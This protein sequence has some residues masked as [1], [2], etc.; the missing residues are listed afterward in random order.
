MVQWPAMKWVWATSMLLL[1]V[2]CLGVGN[3]LGQK[4]EEGRD[5]L[6][7]A[8]A[9]V[10]M[11]LLVLR[12]VFRFHPEWDYALLPSDAYAAVRPWW[13]FPFACVSL[14]IGTRRMSTRFSRRGVAVCAGLLLV[15]VASRLAA[16]AAIDPA[17]L[18]GRPGADGVCRQTTDYS[19][20]AA[21]AATLLSRIGL[22]AGEGEMAEACGTTALTGTDE[23][24]VCRGLRR[25]LAGTG[26]L[27]R[28]VSSDW[29][30]LHGRPLPAMA[31]VAFSFLVDHW[32]VVLEADAG[33]VVVGDPLKSRVVR[34]S[35]ETFLRDWRGVLVV[36][37]NE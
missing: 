35:K 19:C 20:G 36:V 37:Q 28:V 14:G 7:L 3:W 6:A 16:T 15:F 21:A 18:T 4:R 9:A 2:A 13:A 17:S 1:F 22:E 31:V 27:P 33:G 30:D 25:K 23:F 5:R 12:A 26:R 34:L 29:D 10:C 8:A 32:V 11:I 24:G